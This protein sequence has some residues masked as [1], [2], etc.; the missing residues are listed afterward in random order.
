MSES[1]LLIGCGV[2]FFGVSFVVRIWEW[3]RF[4]RSIR[5]KTDESIQHIAIAVR[6]REAIQLES[7]YEQMTKAG[8]RWLAAI[9]EQRQ[10]AIDGVE[11]VESQRAVAAVVSSAEQYARATQLFLTAMESSTAKAMP[12][13]SLD[14]ASVHRWTVLSH[15]A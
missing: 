8:A 6:N 4:A 15:S 13:G 3:S 10:L 12:S 14:T 5:P 7:L 9:Q 2:M 11:S 1:L